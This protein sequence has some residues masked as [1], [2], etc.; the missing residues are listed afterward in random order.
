MFQENLNCDKMTTLTIPFPKIWTFHD[1]LLSC[2]AAAARQLKT[3]RESLTSS[4][5]HENVA[6]LTASAELQL[7]HEIRNG[8]RD[9]YR[10]LIERHQSTISSRMWK[11]SRLPNEH[12]ELVQE[13]FVEAYLSLRN[14]R[15]DAPFEHWLQRI[16]TR[17]GYRFWKKRK[18]T[19]DTQSERMQDIPATMDGGRELDA[20]EAASVVYR[21]LARL[22]TEDRLVMTLLHLEEYSIA[23]IARQMNWSESNVKVRAHRARKKLAEWLKEDQRD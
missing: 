8:N 15:G 3:V 13:V 16:A 10:Q 20:E 6:A 11:F 18:Q 1:A 7:V 4:V 2:C 9:K 22:S 23:E 5:T 21:L 17:V 14:F 12:E 19:R